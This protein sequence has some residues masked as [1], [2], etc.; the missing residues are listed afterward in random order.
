MLLGV[1][2]LMLLAREG[3]GEA[4]PAE[5]TLLVLHRHVS[6]HVQLQVCLLPEC[7]ATDQTFEQPLICNSHCNN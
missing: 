1:L 3:A 4:L 7:L 5:P 6:V 2:Q